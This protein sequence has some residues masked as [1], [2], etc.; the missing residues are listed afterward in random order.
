MHLI[1]GKNPKFKN[2]EFVLVDNWFGPDKENRVWK[3][4]EFYTKDV[5][6]I[7]AEDTVIATTEKGEPKG[8]H[9]RFYL[10][11][12]YKQDQRNVSDILIYNNNCLRDKEFQSTVLK[13]SPLFGRKFTDSNRNYSIVSYYEDADYYDT[14][15][16]SAMWTMLIWFFK[17]PKK[18]KGGDLILN[19]FETAFECKHNRMLLFPSHYEH[20]VTPISLAEEHKNKGMGR[21]TITNFITFV[22]V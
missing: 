7:R 19:D 14:H 22:D 8:K 18:F 1:K 13:K 5:N 4:L 12:Y 21:Y 9:Y 15:T 11:W 20:S 2:P 6:T 17:E 16:D 10:D 3:E